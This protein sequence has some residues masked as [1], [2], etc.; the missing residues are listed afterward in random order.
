[1]RKM[2]LSEMVLDFD[3][4]P[5]GSVDSRHASEIGR[6][7]DAGATLPPM[8]LCKKS[9][10]IVDGFHRH[11][12]YGQRFGEHYETEVVEKTYRNDA[13]LFAD[14]MR[15]NSTHGLPMDTHDKARCVL[16]AQR[17]GIDDDMIADALHVSADYIGSLRVDRTA[18]SGRLVV[19]IKRTIRHMAGR[20]LTKPQV[21][22]NTKLSG[23]NQQFYVNQIITLIES[24]LLD[25]ADEDLLERLKVLHGLLDG[26]LIA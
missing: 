22:A 18:K 3:L 11:R 13:E 19:P 1:M 10:R 23:M 12:V 17:L 6:S 15:F 16:I 5:R 20:Q 25:K 26:I 21:E 7:L 24:D 14:A 4:Y 9:H 2:K 8:V